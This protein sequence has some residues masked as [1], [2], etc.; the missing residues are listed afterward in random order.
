MCLVEVCCCHCL[1]L[2]S[3]HFGEARVGMRRGT[4]DS[5]IIEGK[6]TTEA[7]DRNKQMN[8]GRKMTASPG[9]LL[10]SDPASA[11]VFR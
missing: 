10:L 1:A 6:C 11:W 4:Q 5:S 3:K 2:S 7:R 8:V 9:Q